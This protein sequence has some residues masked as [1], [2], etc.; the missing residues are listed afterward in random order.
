MGVPCSSIGPY[1]TPKR[2]AQKNNEIKKIR[3]RMKTTIIKQIF[4]ILL[5]LYWW[6][7]KPRKVK[8]GEKS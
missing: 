1:V 5:V 2:K 7:E 6:K 3:K 4:G 8:W